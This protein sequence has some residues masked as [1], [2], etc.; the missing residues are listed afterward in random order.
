MTI[1]F[2]PMRS[3][4]YINVSKEDYRHKLQHWLY[5]THI[6]DSISQFEPY[7]TKYSFYN[8]LPVPKDGERFGTY[9]FQLTEH[10]WLVNPMNPQLKVKA[11]SESFTPEV[12]KWQ[13]IV[14]DIESGQVEIAN[15][16]DVRNAGGDSKLP[17]FIFAFL[18]MWW[19]EEF[20]G[21]ERMTSDGP[22]YKWQFL[23]KYPK[24]ISREE[25]DIWLL[26]EVLPKFSEMNEVTRILT[27]KVKQEINNCT[28][29]RVVEIWFDCPSDWH[30]SAVEKAS[31]IKKPSWA[32]CNTFPYLTPKFE[33]A[34]IFLSDIATSNNLQQY[35]GYIPMR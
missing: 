8:A 9:N 7:V 4:I 31:I 22:N 1:E 11:I 25:G 13:G 5:K 2:E 3:L 17:P 34:S 21:S 28:Y 15:P 12:L 24:S 6:P 18:P 33:I 14:P 16:E 19:E 26:E 23:I 29:Q 30:R 20:K 10:H 27:S 35:R 32:R